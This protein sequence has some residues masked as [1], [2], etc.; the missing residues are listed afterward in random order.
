[1]AAE[2]SAVLPML[3][4]GRLGSKPATSMAS[5]AG[6]SPRSAGGPESPNPA[7]ESLTGRRSRPFLR[8][9]LKLK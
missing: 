8:L 3:A 2:C 5:S 7:A 9:G 4:S 1:M 6:T